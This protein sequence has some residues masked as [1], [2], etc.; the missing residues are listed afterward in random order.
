[1]PKTLSQEI[2]S[3]YPNLIKPNQC[4]DNVYRLMSHTR[5]RSEVFNALD[6]QVV[7][8][9]VQA[10]AGSNLYTRHCYFLKGEE[11]VDP[12]LAH[13]P[14]RD[15]LHIKQLKESEYFDLVHHE[16]NPDLFKTLLKPFKLKERELMEQNCFVIG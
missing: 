15:Y 13:L 7:Y 2:K 1:M 16:L 10:V 14:N 8:G 12:T 6:L 4:Y 9:F 5:F 3:Q 11:V